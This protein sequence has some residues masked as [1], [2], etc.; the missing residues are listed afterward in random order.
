MYLIDDLPVYREEKEGEN[1]VLIRNCGICGHLMAIY[2]NKD[3]SY[4]DQICYSPVDTDK[5]K[6]EY[7]EC[8][9]CNFPKEE[10]P[11]RLQ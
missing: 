8:A 6:I 9:M 4:S 10:K 2:I 3:G 11:T 7:W 5:G 1:R